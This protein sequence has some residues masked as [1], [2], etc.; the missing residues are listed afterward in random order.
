MIRLIGRPRGLGAQHTSRP[1]ESPDNLS[2]IYGLVERAPQLW[3]RLS[4]HGPL[5]GWD[6]VKRRHVQRRSRDPCSAGNLLQP[7]T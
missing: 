1:T 3:V 5:I 4:I 2:E 7:N 6:A